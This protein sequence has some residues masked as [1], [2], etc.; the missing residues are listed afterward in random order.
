MSEQ[1]QDQWAIVELFGHQ[2][3]AGR[4]SEH[5]MGGC[6]FVRVDVP[7][8]PQGEGKP[9]LPALTKLFGNGAI[10]G[11]T[12]VDEATALLTAGYLMVRPI[13]PAELRHALGGMDPAGMRQLGL[14]PLD[15]GDYAGDDSA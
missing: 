4:I 5:S 9:A 14:R 11:I 7:P 6:S 2:R 13:H 3:I 1:Q 12:F 10:Y 15:G 8:F